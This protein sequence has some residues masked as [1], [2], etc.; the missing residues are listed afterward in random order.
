SACRWIGRRLGGI[1]RRLD[2]R[3]RVR[4]EQNVMD[5]LGLPADEAQR[6]VKRNF[7]NY[8]M[9]IGEFAKLLRYNHA[10][11][12]RLIDIGDCEPLCRKL[13]A[14][15]NGVI[16]L[17]GHFGNWEWENVMPVAYGLSG[18]AIARPLDNPFLDRYVKKLREKNGMK[19]LDKGSGFR[20]ALRTLHRKEIIAFLA[21][22]DSGR[23]GMMS[24]FLGLDASTT[25]VPAEMALRTG[26]PMLCVLL[27]RNPSG[28]KFPFAVIR[29]EPIR[30][31]PEAEPN[32]E[33]RRLVDTMNENL[34]SMILQA[35]EQW[36]WLHRRWKTR[37][38]RGKNYRV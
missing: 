3:H 9:I 16:F 36:F 24:P 1:F 31:N 22:Q 20:A 26:A 2:K 7:Q 27:R 17:T 37:E 6:F 18:G 29:S 15:G 11:Y 5:R 32:G 10:D 13:L 12:R 33:I 30:A 28:S 14:E 19:I 38:V 4:A 25:T 34:S 8:G 35:P 21:D 23:K